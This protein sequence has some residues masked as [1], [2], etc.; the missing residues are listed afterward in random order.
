[1]KD[2]N[3][4]ENDEQQ[5]KDDANVKLGVS[6]PSGATASTPKKPMLAKLIPIKDTIAFSKRVE[7]H[8]AKTQRDVQSCLK[9]TRLNKF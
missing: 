5:K 7:C 9:G 1:M 4:V 3:F 6:T 2:N 8:H